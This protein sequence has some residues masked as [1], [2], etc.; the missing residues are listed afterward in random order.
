MKSTTEKIPQFIKSLG[1]LHDSVLL[2]LLWNAAER[3]LEIEFDDLYSNFEGMPEYQGPIRA[4]F[5]FNE[6]T[7]FKTNIDFTE[8][9]FKIYDWDFVR[10]GTPDFAFEILF[11]PEGRLAVDCRHIEYKAVTH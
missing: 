2:L 1:G 5:I 7:K 9:G 3:R 4:K 11:S 6:V 8:T 10:N